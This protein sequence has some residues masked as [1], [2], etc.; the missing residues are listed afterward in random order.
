MRF[1]LDTGLFN[2]GDYVKRGVACVNCHADSVKGNGMANKNVCWQCHNKPADINRYG[3]TKF[4]HTQHISQ[5]K[6]EC[7][8]CHIQIEHNLSAGGGFN[9]QPGANK[10]MMLDN[11][12]A[13]CHEQTHLGPDSLYRGIGGI[14]VPSMPSPM[15]RT[16]VDCIGCHKKKEV[17]SEVAEVVGQTF[18]GEQKSCTYCHGEKYQGRLDEWRKT[19]NEHLA[20]A[21]AAY[22]KATLAVQAAQIGETDLLQ[23]KRLMNF[24]DHDIRLVKLGRGVHNV[25]YATALLNYAEQ[26]CGQAQAI[27]EG[28][29]VP[30]MK[31]IVP[32]TMPTVP[33]TT[34]PATLPANHPATGGAK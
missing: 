27:A 24:A 12:C 9:A 25:N 6:V 21:E 17:S 23:I 34:K 10:V 33:A 5:H 26:C 4:L 20:T 18:L 28:R 22:A 31:P 32:A 30:A 3:D 11:P 2:H 13:Q 7:S 29:P 8:S 14:G 16:Q 15:F 19:V 1:R